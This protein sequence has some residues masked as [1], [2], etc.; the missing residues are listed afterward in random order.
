MYRKNYSVVL[1][2][3][4]TLFLPREPESGN[5]PDASDPLVE[6]NSTNWYLY[7]LN[8][9]VPDNV[10]KKLIC[11]GGI[12]PEGAKAVSSTYSSLLLQAGL[13]TLVL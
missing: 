1:Y 6:L 10:L 9:S 4:Q 2:R 5:Y 11:Y 7:K 12:I 13:Q 3:K 8:Q